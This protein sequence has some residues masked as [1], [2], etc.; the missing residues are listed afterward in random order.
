MPVVSSDGQASIIMK[1]IAEQIPWTWEVS[2]N[3]EWYGGTHVALSTT[4]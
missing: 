3:F 2:V 4:A 1:A